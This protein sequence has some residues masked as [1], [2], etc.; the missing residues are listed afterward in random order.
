[1]RRKHCDLQ[2]LEFF[3]KEDEEGKKE[4]QDLTVSISLS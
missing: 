4:L 3:L 2:L 1:M